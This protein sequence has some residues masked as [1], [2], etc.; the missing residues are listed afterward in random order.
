MKPSEHERDAPAG[1]PREQDEHEERTEACG[2]D[3]PDEWAE[4]AERGD[5]AH[6]EQISDE[7]NFRADPDPPRAKPRANRGD[8]PRDP[9]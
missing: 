2:P 7:A 5:G 6:A 4:L 8:E 1:S 9:A 3:H